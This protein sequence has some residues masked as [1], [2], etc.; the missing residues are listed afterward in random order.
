[1]H[2]ETL[3]Y[4]STRRICTKETLRLSISPRLPLEHPLRPN[5]SLENV[6][7]HVGVHRG[8]GVVQKKQVAVVVH[9]PLNSNLFFNYF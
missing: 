8:E 1:M 4:F 7:P 6:R 5:D 9:S 2:F 3:L